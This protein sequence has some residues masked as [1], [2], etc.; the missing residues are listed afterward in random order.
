VERDQKVTRTLRSVGWVGLSG[1]EP[2]NEVLERSR[3][4]FEGRGAQV[5]SLPARSAAI[6]RFTAPPAD[7]LAA[8]ARLL[9]NEELDLLLALR[10][11]YGLSQL[12]PLIDFDALARAIEERGL[13]IC[14]YSDFTALLLGLFATTGAVGFTGPSAV[15]FGQEP[16]DPF[17]ERCFWQAF[18]GT[19]EPLRYAT[20]ASDL[21]VEGPLWGGNLTMLISL[22][23][24]PYLPKIEGGILF[25]EDVNEHP[26][27]VDR[28]L[29]QL[30]YAGI[31]ERQKAV[32][33]GQFTNYRLSEYDAGYDL[34]Q[35][36]DELSKRI[37]CPIVPGLPFGHVA[38]QATLPI[39]AI[40]RLK[41]A[42]GAAVL[43]LPARAGA[44]RSSVKAGHVPS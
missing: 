26:Y 41:V 36:I 43:E 35:V 32:L 20:Q 17:A 39:G 37:S 22:L 42:G 16:V 5:T 34:P 13:M 10:G 44:A 28:M 30:Q 25:L 2:R 19:P 29:L 31:L 8:L 40:G 21:D 6:Q 27:R 12:L 18:D 33:L 24:T 7:R 38:H 23:A 9:Q 11:G 14:G 3:R 15:S 1:Y 4:Y